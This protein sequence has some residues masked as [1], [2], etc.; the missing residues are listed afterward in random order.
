MDYS[1]IV[2]PA[3]EVAELARP[4]QAR[5]SFCEIGY[6]MNAA[7]ARHREALGNPRYFRSQVF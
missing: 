7:T 4:W 3:V 5:P 1:V 2:R 6:G